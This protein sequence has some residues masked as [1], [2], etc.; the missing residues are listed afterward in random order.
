MQRS[1]VCRFVGWLVG[2]LIEGLVAD[3]LDERVNVGIVVIIIHHAGSWHEALLLSPGANAA[4]TASHVSFA[5]SIASAHGPPATFQHDGNVVQ[6]GAQTG[7][8][9]GGQCLVS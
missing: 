5:S 9:G 3:W 1:R 2:A 4:I 6:D 8:D 7:C